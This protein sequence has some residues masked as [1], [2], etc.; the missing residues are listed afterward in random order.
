MIWKATELFSTRVIDLCPIMA[1]KLNLPTLQS[2]IVGGQPRLRIEC[3]AEAS[4]EA[5][6]RSRLSSPNTRP[7]PSCSSAPNRFPGGSRRGRASE[8]Q[9]NPCLS[10]HPYLGLSSVSIGRYSPARGVLHRRGPSGPQ[11]VISVTTN[12]T[13]RCV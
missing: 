7:A 11:P 4:P 10:S 9:E 8:R 12:K 6:N 13:I 5:P 3:N 1:L 2:S